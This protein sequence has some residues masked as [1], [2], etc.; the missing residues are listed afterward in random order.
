MVRH[1]ST[2][3]TCLPCGRGA[4]FSLG[5][6]R[7]A[8]P[9]SEPLSRIQP[10]PGPVPP[11]SNLR[12]HPAFAFTG[13]HPDLFCPHSILVN[14]ILFLS[15]FVSVLVRFAAVVCL[16]HLNPASVLI[17]PWF[18]WFPEPPSSQS[19]FRS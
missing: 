4:R 17:P 14:V 16:P 3:T 11:R 18:S 6:R 5:P 13:L 9:H 12:P 15:F 10:S 7:S 8:Q 2:S 1:T 19:R